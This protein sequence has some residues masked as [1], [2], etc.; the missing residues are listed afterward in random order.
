M[1]RGDAW[2]TYILLCSGGRLYTGVST[3][4]ERRFK[5]HSTGRGALFTRL[6]PPVAIL[7]AKQYPSFK[8]AAT[9]ERNL[10]RGGL[11]ERRAWIEAW[12]WPQRRGC[13]AIPIDRQSL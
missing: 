6:N 7:A 1:A 3:D 8:E 11:A 9:T 5:D 10:K 13:S 4:V 12:P 2:W